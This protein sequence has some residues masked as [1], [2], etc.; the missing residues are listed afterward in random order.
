MSIRR[1]LIVDQIEY[2]VKVMSDDLYG[3]LCSVPD[4]WKAIKEDLVPK[5]NIIVEK[6]HYSTRMK[7]YSIK[8]KLTAVVLVGTTKSKSRYFKLVLHVG[9]ASDLELAVFQQQLGLL[10]PEM[11]Y[12]KL[13]DTARVTRIDFASDSFS[14][15]HQSAIAFRPHSTCS[16]VW[17]DKMSAPGTLYIGSKASDLHFRIYDKKRQQEQTKKTAVPWAKWLRIEA[18]IR[19]PGCSGSELGSAIDNP[20]QG[21]GF[22]DVASAHAVSSDA[23]W[24]YFLGLCLAVGSPMALA[25]TKDKSTKKLFRA[26]LLESAVSWWKPVEVWTKLPQALSR[27][28]PTS[29]LNQH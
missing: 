21:L 15:L 12:S 19:R 28:A 25:E 9:K 26:R 16:G 4:G 17:L 27:I 8:G 11:E 10:A 22:A 5:G 3:F 13:F 23:D 7:Y 6:G 20:F 29:I 2:T 1:T 14:H 24:Q 18:E